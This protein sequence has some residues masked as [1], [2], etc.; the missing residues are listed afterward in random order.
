MVAEFGYGTADVARILGLSSAQIRM[1]VQQGHVTPRRDRKGGFRFS[2]PDLVVLRTAKALRSQV[3]AQRLHR[4]LRRLRQ[5]LPAGRALSSVAIGIDGAQ[6]VVRDGERAWEAATGQGLLGFAVGELAQQVAP[7]ARRTLAARSVPGQLTADD[8]YE[9][10]C[11]LEAASDGEARNAYQ[12]ALALAPDHAA[13]H[14]NLG[15]LQHEAGDA[16]AAVAHYRAALHSDGRNATAAFN[17]GVALEDLG[18]PAEAERAYQDAL[19]LDP[20]S[21]DAHFNL[22]RLCEQRGDKPGAV[23]HLREYQRLARQAGS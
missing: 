1:L 2:L 18:Q 11:D 13:A 5:Q 14:I 17:L 7:I 8:W 22:A 19:A 6:V 9:L 4:A 10:G 16:A 21:A 23:R 15:R 20:A 3:S 12:R